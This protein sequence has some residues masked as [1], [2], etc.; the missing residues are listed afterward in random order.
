M[1][2]DMKTTGFRDVGS[3]MEKNVETTV[4]LWII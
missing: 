4:F 1:E 3:G 2:K